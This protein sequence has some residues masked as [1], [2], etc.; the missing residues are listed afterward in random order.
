[1]HAKLDQ[2]HVGGQEGSLAEA[3]SGASVAPSRPGSEGNRRK[4][5]GW[6]L[7]ASGWLGCFWP[8]RSQKGLK[9]NQAVSRRES[10][11]P[12]LAIPHPSPCLVSSHLTL[13]VCSISCPW[14]SPFPILLFLLSAVIPAQSCTLQLSYLSISL[15]RNP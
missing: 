12:A 11:Q 5:G 9:R 15:P 4:A 3:M 13:L 8:S 1:M 6:S 7:G 10:Q 14:A 2:V